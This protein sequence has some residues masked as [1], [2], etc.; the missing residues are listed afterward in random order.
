MTKEQLL[1]EFNRAVD[2]LKGTFNIENQVAEI[3]ISKVAT[4]L[5]MQYL[6]KPNIP[7]NQDMDRVCNWLCDNLAVSREDGTLKKVIENYPFVLGRSLE[8]LESSKKMCP[9]DVN[10]QIAVAEDPALIDETYNCDGICA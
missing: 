6:G 1:G 10:F 2:Y 5:N 3:S 8:E 9:E 4:G 7:Q